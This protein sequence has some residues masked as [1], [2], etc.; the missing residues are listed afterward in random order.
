MSRNFYDY[1]FYK[2][3][4]SSNKKGEA[5]FIRSENNTLAKILIFA[6]RGI[7]YDRNKEELAWN[8]KGEGYELKRGYLSPGFS[9]ILG[10]VSSPIKDKKGV[11]WQTEFEGKDGLEK[12]YSDRIQGING[13]K[14]VEIDALGQIQYQNVINAPVR[15]EDLITTIDSRIQSKLFT[16][17]QELS[18]KNSFSGGAGIIIDVTNGELLSLVSFPEYNSEILS[19]GSDQELINKYL[20]DKRKVFLDRTISGL[21]VPGS[22]IKPILAL[23]ALK[24]NIIDPNKEIL[25][26]GFISIPNPYVKD[27]ETIFKDWKI[28]GYTA[29]REAIAVSS[30]VYFYTIGGGFKDQRGLGI[31]NI[32]KYAKLFGIGEKTNIDLPDEKSGN[33]PSPIWKEKNF[34]GDPWRLGNTYHTAIGQYGF[35][36]TPIEMV[37]AISAI[38]NNGT[39]I[40][41]HLLLE[42]TED[43]K[44]FL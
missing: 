17:I 25:S 6:D 29:M 3:W 35:Q 21:Y 1:I 27:G 10:Y 43:N 28:H 31:S 14:I 38:A 16:L 23:G 9:H 42:N 18:E 5:Y 19:E 32:E 22:I 26:N 39:L 44:K 36:V 13:S 2:T 4:I 40:T 11:Y 7:I 20:T 41:P 37:R 33:I 12:Q 15:G 30:D 8:K 24:E 34:P